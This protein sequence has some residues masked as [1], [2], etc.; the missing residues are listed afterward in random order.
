MGAPTPPTRHARTRTALVI[1]QI[2]HR[3]WGGCTASRK[4]H[5]AP[6][7]CKTQMRSGTGLTASVHTPCVIKFATQHIPTN[8]NR[9]LS[10]RSPCSM[11]TRTNMHNCALHK[12]TASSALRALIVPLPPPPP[13]A[14]STHLCVSVRATLARCTQIKLMAH[15]C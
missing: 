2:M 12:H 5:T 7:K 3:A 6:A 14:T 9:V 10:A 4:P 8:F 1:T 13:S 11:F 15:N